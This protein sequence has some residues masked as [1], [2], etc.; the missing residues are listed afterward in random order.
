[1]VSRLL[2]GICPPEQ[3]AVSP[4][5]RGDFHPERQS[6]RVEPGHQDDR[7]DADRVHP[8]GVAVRSAAQPAILRHGLIGRRHLRGRIDE[9]IQLQPV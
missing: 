4:L 9:P 5:P 6:A 7:G 8:T 1:M 3:N 2:V